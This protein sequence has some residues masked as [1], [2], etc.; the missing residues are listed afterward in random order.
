MAFENDW[1]WFNWLRDA[2]NSISEHQA[3]GGMMAAQTGGAGGQTPLTYAGMATGDNDVLSSIATDGGNKTIIPEAI[4]SG[5]IQQD[6]TA[7]Q[8]PLTTDAKTYGDLYNMDAEQMIQTLIE[9][10]PSNATG[11]LEM[12]VGM[13]ANR[14]NTQQAYLREQDMMKNQASWVREGLEK[15]GINPILAYQ[16]MNGG[17]S[18]AGSA[19]VPSSSIFSTQVQKETQGKSTNTKTAG[20]LLT[21]L[22]AIIGIVAKAA[23]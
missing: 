1:G 3:Y 18:S 13:K 11:W 20:I 8:S 5:D 23:L 17:G 19:S 12:L 15:A 2:L 4:G 7:D 10:D 9:R 21:F 16:Y 22:A 6:E 14:E